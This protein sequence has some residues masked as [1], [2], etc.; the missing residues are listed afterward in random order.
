LVHAVGDPE[1]LPEVPPELLLPDPEPD[2]PEVPPEP[3]ELLPEPPCKP[4][5]LPLPD[6]LV[7]ALPPELFSKLPE[8]PEELPPEVVAPELLPSDGPDCIVGDDEPPHAPAAAAMARRDAVTRP[9][10]HTT[11]GDTVAA[12]IR[13][14][15][16][17]WFGAR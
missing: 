9:V 10:R 8:L 6:V 11:T 14:V 3:P 12:C 1:L 13:R 5:E 7:P 15:V 16:C 2:V 17:H 4:E